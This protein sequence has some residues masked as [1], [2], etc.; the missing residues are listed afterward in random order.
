MSVIIILAALFQIISSKD[1]KSLKRYIE[2][3]RIGDD[4]ENLFIEKLSVK[5]DDGYVYISKYPMNSGGDIDG[6]L[7]SKKGIIVLEIKNWRGKFAVYHRKIFKNFF[8][9]L[10]RYSDAFEQ[11][12]NNRTEL[13][14]LIKG[15]KIRPWLGFGPRTNYN[16]KENP[17]VFVVNWDNIAEHVF[18]LKDILEPGE[19]ENVVDILTSS[20]KIKPI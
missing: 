10:Q 20:T 8:H 4:G 2:K 19:V 15:Y 17:G 6:I 14:R 12:E 16:I 11:V 9:K 13:E 1:R 7:I 5:L 3:F 18:S